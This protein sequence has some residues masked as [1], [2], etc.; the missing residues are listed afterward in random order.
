MKNIKICI[1]MLLLSAVAVSCFEENEFLIP[2]DFAWVGFQVSRISVREDSGSGVEATILLSS[3]PLSQQLSLTYTVSSSDATEGVDYSIPAG[4][5]TAIIPAGSASATITLIDAVLN[6]ENITGNRK[7][8]FTIT[9]AGG[10]TLGGPDGEYGTTL[11]VTLVEDDLSLYGYTSF[12]EPVPAPSGIYNVPDEGT[13]EGTS[14]PNLP[15]DNNPVDYVSV[16]GEMGFDTYYTEGDPGGSDDIHL[17]VTNATDLDDGVGSYFDGSQGYVSEDADGELNLEFDEITLGSMT[18]IQVEIGFY[19]TTGSSF[20]DDDY[21]IAVWRTEDGDEELFEIT[22]GYGPGEDEVYTPGG[23]SMI[24][25]WTTLT[26]FPENMKT[27][28]LVIIWR[29]SSGG[30]YIYFDKI[31]IKGF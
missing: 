7:V 10:Y 27:G 31:A 25:K 8:T 23:S 11:E 30:E 20:E 12:E 16:G 2:D 15:G 28:K 1:L 14:L 4:S 3:K 13:P 26:G 22:G 21:V 29:S 5:G 6:N 18:L 19:F 24:G 17:G 9:D